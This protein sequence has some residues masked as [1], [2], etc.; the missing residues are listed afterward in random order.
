MPASFIYKPNTYK[1][2]VVLVPSEG[3]QTPPV[4]TLPDGSKITGKYLNTNEGRHQFVFPRDI[5]GQQGIT[6][7]YGG[8]SGS[9]GNGAMSYEGS[10][11]GGWD[12]RFKGS[13]Q[14]PSAGAGGS[15]QSAG[16][17]G[18]LPN[19]YMMMFQ[20]VNFNP[21]SYKPI[22]YDPIQAAP[23]KFTDPI[24][25]AKRYNTFNKEQEQNAFDTGIKRGQQLTDLDTNAISNFANKMSGLQMNLVGAENAFNQAQRLKAVDFALPDLRSTLDAKR[26]RASTYAS[27]RL[28]NSAEDRAYEVA[29][30]SASADGSFVRGFGDDSV[31]GKRTSDI[32]SAQQRLG[33]S[34]MGEGMLNDW[35]SQGSSI[36]IDT[37]LKSSIS[38]RLPSTPP[39][40]PSQQATQQQGN[41]ANMTTVPLQ[42]GISS[43][44][45]Q[46]QFSTNLEQ[47]TRTFN[48][49]NTF[50]KDQ[51]NAGNQ[52]QTDSFNASNDLGAQEFNS[53]GAFQ[54]SQAQFSGLQT[55][56]DRATNAA[57]RA[58]DI[59]RA[60]LHN[61]AASSAADSNISAQ[62]D[63]GNAGAAGQI[64]G[65]IIGGAID[66]FTGG[67]GGGGVVGDILGAIGLGGS[68]GGG[69]STPAQTAS[70]MSG[71]SI[72]GGGHTFAPTGSQS[73]S[74]TL[75]SS[76]TPQVS[77]DASQV[78]DINSQ[79]AAPPQSGTQGGASRSYSGSS[80][81][82]SSS[83][84]DPAATAPMVSQGIK[85]TGA[86]L[87]N[88]GRSGPSTPQVSSLGNGL[89]NGAN[90]AQEITGS[91]QTV[92]TPEAEMSMADN[93]KAAAIKNANS[94]EEQANIESIFSQVREHLDTGVGVKGQAAGIAG[95]IKNY[96]DYSDPERVRGI[97]N[98][99]FAGQDL[100]GAYG[101]KDLNSDTIGKIPVAGTNNRMT[102]KDAVSLQNSGY[103]VSGLVTHW[104]EI[105]A[106]TAALGGKE[107]LL[108]VASTGRDLNLAGTDTPESI[109]QRQLALREAGASGAGAW[110]AGAVSVPS[111]N[112][113]Q[114]ERQ[115]YVAVGTSSDGQVV[116]VPRSAAASAGLTFGIVGSGMDEVGLNKLPLKN[117][118]V[119]QT[120]KNNYD[121]WDTDFV[122]KNTMSMGDRSAVASGLYALGN[123]DPYKLGTILL[124]DLHKNGAVIQEPSN[125]DKAEGLVTAIEDKAANTATGGLSGKADAVDKEYFDGK[126]RK[127]IDKANPMR[128]LVVKGVEV[129]LDA[130]DS[131]T[132]KFSD[133][134]GGF[135]GGK[136]EAQGQRDNLRSL[137]ED[138]GF[139]KNNQME[140]LDGTT[141]DIGKDGGRDREWNDP[142]LRRPDQQNVGKLGAYDL[143]YTRD[144]DAVM[145]LSGN[146][147]AVLQFGNAD[148]NAVRQMGNYYT[149][150]VVSK[151]KSAE[152]NMANFS[153]VQAEM[154]NQFKR[155][156]IETRDEAY[157]LSNQ[158]KTE[159]RVTDMQLV[160]I[161]QGINLAFD[162]NAYQGATQL[163]EGV[164]L[165][166]KGEDLKESKPSKN[167][168][169]SEAVP[170]DKGPEKFNKLEG[171]KA[172]TSQKIQKQDKIEVEDFNLPKIDNSPMEIV[173]V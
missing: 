71:G 28:L 65:A 153:T 4:I 27:G 92:S 75:G 74:A 48:A 46:N 87:Q 147:L 113:K 133:I 126:I 39:I 128:P 10:S 140:F 33:I 43:E 22:N 66:Y 14:D 90:S 144:I 145:N 40:L 95:F 155:A 77:A 51:F 60:E 152:L 53:S 132:S 154:A 20:P 42:F 105:S 169:S 11:I 7:D 167:A 103:N 91:F 26:D 97:T 38:Q 117:L 137:L 119:S 31:F 18:G 120:A 127:T 34:Q 69:G 80:I 159:G 8:Q 125:G 45:N 81:P 151:S 79:V 168:P 86:L 172:S 54:A 94:P 150:G 100:L 68:A 62:Q 17:Y 41:L 130:T 166:R 142:S 30:R 122:P 25:A 88:L 64:G 32:L 12:E 23:Y 19:P 35:I 82:V 55:N 70:G 109:N 149:N 136:N 114:V 78:E 160:Q 131:I 44:I 2:P 9:I 83:E 108:S 116:A 135:S 63:A 115:G 59:R 13:M 37:P 165:G 123:K 104:D 24:E 84:F 141:F 21:I 16:G 124:T 72:T 129:G 96:N 170:V 173:T 171:P 73:L 102:V 29:A 99:S 15:P 52:L 148:D 118:Q 164:K 146:A 61:E 143:D 112:R 1:G 49:G 47:G 5:I 138:N 110:G 157:A 139:T 67:K 162:K 57:N 107:D 163:L 158:L 106:V 6:I 98:I 134:K 50:S 111:S 36:L 89:A 3:P 161:Q 76:S 101:V 121:N 56:Y 85:Q 93:L 58:D 156:G